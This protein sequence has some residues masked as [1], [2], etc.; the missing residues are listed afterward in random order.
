MAGKTYDF[1]AGTVGSTVLTTDTPSSGDVA[2]DFSGG[3][4]AGAAYE[5]T[6]VSAA[7]G[8]K[9]A[10]YANRATG[11]DNY[12]GWTTASPAAS[13]YG[14]FYFMVDN[15]AASTRI[16]QFRS[17]QGGSTIGGFWLSFQS[18]NWFL[19][20]TNSTDSAIYNFNVNQS[21]LTLNTWYRCEWFLQV[22]GASAPTMQGKLFLG[23]STTAMEDSGSLSGST[24]YTGSTWS[25]MRFGINDGSA[26]VTNNPSS[27]GYIYLDNLDSFETTWPG[28]AISSSNTHYVRYR[29]GKNVSTG[30]V[31]FTVTLMQGTTQIAQWTH[32]NVAQGFTTYEQNLTT[33]QAASITNA[34]D[35]RL[36]FVTS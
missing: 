14:R 19:R 36:R 26:T 12:R 22:N 31:N 6:N 20:M 10:R 32:S 3:P 1:E 29:I 9:A 34:A 7:S 15:I 13:F 33:A 18:P 17:A 2:F 28:P 11:G 35:L 30:T 24:S 23:D 21:T 4:P 27:T 8:T 25:S 16:I 5:Y